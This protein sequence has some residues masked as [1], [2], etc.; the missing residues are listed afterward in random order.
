MI[1]LAVRTFQPG[2]TD[3]IIFKPEEMLKKKE[4]RKKRP[5]GYKNLK[6]LLEPCL[7]HSL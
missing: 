6:L 1:L 2:F 3:K 4:K 5:C 7:D